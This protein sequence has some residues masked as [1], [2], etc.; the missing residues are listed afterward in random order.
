MIDAIVER[1]LAGAEK[2]LRAE[3]ALTPVYQ[4]VAEYRVVRRAAK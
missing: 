4:I 2:R 1:Q 3:L